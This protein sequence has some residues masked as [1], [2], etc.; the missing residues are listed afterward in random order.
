MRISLF[1]PL[2]P[3]A[4]M[5]ILATSLG[6]QRDSAQARM[7]VELDTSL[8]GPAY[9]FS[10]HE[11]SLLLARVF[12]K[13]FE[14]GGGEG[15]R[16]NGPAFLC[17]ALGRYASR[18]DPPAS[19]LRLLVGHQPPVRPLSACRVPQ[20]LDRDIGVKD[21]GTGKSAWLL[22][23]TSLGSISGDT[24]AVRSNH[25]VGPRWG[26]GWSCKVLHEHDDWRVVAC[27]MTW[28]S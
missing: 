12:E 7:A 4:G 11:D 13:T 5:V 23:I 1:R 26:A 24:V 18:S 3:F 16:G 6:A 9:S 25:Y 28:I 17:L 19:V 15:G 22:T 10:G 8:N 27:S 2:L 20:L 21:T 14:L